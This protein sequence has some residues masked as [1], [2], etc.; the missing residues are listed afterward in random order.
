M[1]TDALPSAGTPVGRRIF[2][3]MLGFGVGGVLVGAKVSDLVGRVMAPITSRDRLGISDLFPGAG[4]FRIYSVVGY[5]PK[6]TDAEYQLTVD[7]LV[8]TPLTLSLAQL[9]AM[10]P[11]HL[12]KDFQCVTGWRVHQVPW[13]GVRLADVLDAAG[14]Q[15]GGRAVR[16]W[17]F[18][19][20]Y[21]ESLTMDQAR[22]ADVIVAYEMQGGPVPSVHGGPVR[23]YV[24]PMYGY[25]SCKWL[26]RIEVTSD[27][28]E[29]YWERRG[30][31]VDGWIGRSNGRSDTPV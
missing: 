24:A 4:G 9:Q 28:I 8:G 30:Y 7:G 13:T 27:V 12:V 5:L 6:R 10:P 3:G 18:D 16:F 2:L 21:T 11:T 31:D 25:K 29:G 19:G 22:R 17:S 26:A 1:G 20:S 23:M 15:A 14:V